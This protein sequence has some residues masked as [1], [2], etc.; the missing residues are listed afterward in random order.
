MRINLIPDIKKLSLKKFLQMLAHFLFSHVLSLLWGNVLVFSPV[1]SCPF[2]LWPFHFNLNSIM[3][4]IIYLFHS[5]PFCVNM[6]LLFSR[7][8]FCYLSLYLYLSAII[9][10]L[11]LRYCS[12]SILLLP[13]ISLPVS[14][15]MF[16]LVFCSFYLL[17]ILVPFLPH[18]PSPPVSFFFCFKFS[19]SS[20]C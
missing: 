12:F 1:L 17:L 3:S 13:L 7:F 20:V 11:L 15:C 9:F 10:S 5:F 16:Y 19:T 14:T 6:L 18:S 8:S 2:L 4:G